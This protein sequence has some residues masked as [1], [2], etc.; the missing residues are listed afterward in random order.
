MPFF[1]KDPTLEALA[2]RVLAATWQ[3]FPTLARNQLALTWLVYDPPVFV[4]TGGA[5]NPSDFWSQSLRGVS[6]RGLECIY[7]ASVVKLFYLVAAHEWLEKGMLTPSQELERAMQD[8][9]TDSSNDGTGL[10]VD[11]LTGTTSGPEL[12]PAPFETWK[13]QRH[14]INRY[15]H[16]LQWEELASINVC[17]KTWNDGPYG[18]ERAFY[19]EHMDNRNMLT[20]DATARLL[21]S[22][23]GG[24]AVSA[25]RSAAMLNALQRSIDPAALAADPE[26]QVT[27]FLGQGLPPQ[28][29]LWSKAGLTSWVRHDAMYVEIPDRS[30]YLLVVFTEGREHQG[31]EAILPFISQQVVAVLPELAK[32][33]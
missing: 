17:Q 2:D 11:M 3:E 30:P 12:P 13:Q 21:H 25:G 20:T 1:R 26:N 31:N 18:R 7:P 15:F 24:V 33:Q 14:I 16:S 23:L 19:G 10:V 27:G 4:N 29:K 6:Y 5:L 28:A 32:S 22:I 8:M 9:I